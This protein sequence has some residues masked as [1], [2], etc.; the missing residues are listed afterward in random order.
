MKSE[1]TSLYAA[2]HKIDVSLNVIFL[3]DSFLFFLNSG[4]MMIF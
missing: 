4:Q 2:K 1:V 3:V